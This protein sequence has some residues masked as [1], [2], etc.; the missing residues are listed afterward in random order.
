MKIHPYKGARTK[1]EMV[2]S[3]PLP[4]MTVNNKLSVF[5]MLNFIPRNRTQQHGSISIHRPADAYG[6]LNI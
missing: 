2:T 6:E 5:K 1:S 3:Y 4:L